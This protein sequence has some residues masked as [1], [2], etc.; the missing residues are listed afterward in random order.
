MQNPVDASYLADS[1][2]LFRYFEHAGQVLKA[3]SVI[4]KRTGP[5]EATIREFGV[6]DGRIRVGPPLK[7]FRGVMTGVPLYQGKMNSLLGEG[8]E[9]GRRGST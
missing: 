5:H 3:I 7:D 6:A 1:V 9:G 8:D 4:K 2:V